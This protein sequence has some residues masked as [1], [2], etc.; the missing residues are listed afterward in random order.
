MNISGMARAEVLLE[1]AEELRLN[2]EPR[3]ALLAEARATTVRALE[4]ERNPK[5][6]LGPIK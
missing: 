5:Y 4:R 3:A 2:G 1:F 6:F